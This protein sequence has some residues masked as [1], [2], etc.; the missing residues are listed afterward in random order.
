MPQSHTDPQSH[1]HTRASSNWLSSPWWPISP[2][3]E[4]LRPL[5]ALLPTRGVKGTTSPQAPQTCHS[6][7]RELPGDEPRPRRAHLSSAP[8]AAAL[9]NP[10]RG[11]PRVW[12]S[13]AGVGPGLASSAG[14]G[15]EK[16]EP[17]RASSSP[18][19]GRRGWMGPPAEEA[20]LP[21]LF[22]LCGRAWGQQER[23]FPT[24]P[25]P[26]PTQPSPA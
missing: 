24:R 18:P 21:L 22:G 19:S 3:G 17:L 2:H 5:D 11:F 20:R 9:K 7:H 6:R 16:E 14:E 23:P 8:A 13:P 12:A 10:P 1:L 15:T 26:A 25:S 4:P